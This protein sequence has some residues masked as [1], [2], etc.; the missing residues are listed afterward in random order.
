VFPLLH[1]LPSAL[2]SVAGFRG[3]R[4]PKR[5]LKRAETGHREGVNSDPREASEEEEILHFP[6]RL[7]T[8]RP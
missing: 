2:S 4:G 3:V 8:E 1:L 7:L 6:V 5:P